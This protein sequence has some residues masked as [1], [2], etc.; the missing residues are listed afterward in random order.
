MK[1]LIKRI[2]SGV[3]AGKIHAGDETKQPEY[4]VCVP[5]LT[6]PMSTKT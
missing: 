4:I 6:V 5:P 3:K 1:G 2:P